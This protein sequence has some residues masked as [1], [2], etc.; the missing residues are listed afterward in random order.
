MLCPKCENDIGFGNQ[1]SLWD[2]LFGYDAGIDGTVI[3]IECPECGCQI[4][5]VTVESIDEFEDVRSPALGED[6]VVPRIKKG[7]KK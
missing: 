7:K 6:V 4:G 2:E 5:S 3:M 1:M